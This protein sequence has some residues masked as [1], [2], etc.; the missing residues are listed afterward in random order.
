MAV[1]HVAT[2]PSPHHKPLGTHFH[3][4]TLAISPTP[5]HL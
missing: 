1:P 4:H 3:F 2:R 5:G